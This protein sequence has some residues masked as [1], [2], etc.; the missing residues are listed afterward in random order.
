MD[1]MEPEDRILF[2]NT[3]SEELGDD[4]LAHR[5]AAH[6]SS[7]GRMFENLIQYSS[8]HGVAQFLQRGAI[9]ALDEGDV[10]GQQIGQAQAARDLVCR[11]LQETGK[12]RFSVPPGASICSSRWTG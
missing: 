6:A 8:S 5:L 4:R 1:I 3:F 11:K 9:S 12:V 7:L 2:V 10:P